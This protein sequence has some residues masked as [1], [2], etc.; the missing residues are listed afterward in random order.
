MALLTR[1]L[2]LKQKMQLYLELHLGHLAPAMTIDETVQ[3]FSQSY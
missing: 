3:D 2:T 1:E